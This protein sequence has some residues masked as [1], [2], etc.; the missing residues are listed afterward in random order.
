[1]IFFYSEKATSYQN[2]DTMINRQTLNEA[3]L[4]LEFSNQVATNSLY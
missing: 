4:K 1:M 3:Y 2:P